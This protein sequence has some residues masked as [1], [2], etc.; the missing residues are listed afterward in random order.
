MTDCT[1]QQI[2]TKSRVEP[3]PAS[4]KSLWQ[5]III[6]SLKVLERFREMAGEDYR[7]LVG[8]H[9]RPAACAI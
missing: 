6:I 4:T 5:R 9:R 3:D 7:S 8:H 2:D 1:I